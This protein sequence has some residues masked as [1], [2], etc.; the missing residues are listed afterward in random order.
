M[1]ILPSYA[2]AAMEAAVDDESILQPAELGTPKEYEIDFETGQLTGKI[3]EGK[4]ALKVWIWLC[5]KTQRF[6]FAIYSWDYGCD[7]EQY[8]G[9][10]LTD[11]YFMTDCEDELREA[12]TINP[13]ITDVSAFY[14]ERD[15]SRLYIEFLVDTTLGSFEVTGYV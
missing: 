7:F 4:D 2:I 9:S 6:A 14:G 10:V 8:I 12:L 5:L 15:G 1:S 13:W 11:E 3:V